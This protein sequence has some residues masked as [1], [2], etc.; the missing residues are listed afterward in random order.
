MGLP[1]LWGKVRIT[2]PLSKAYRATQLG[3]VMRGK[4]DDEREPLSAA[5]GDGSGSKWKGSLI[6]NVDVQTRQTTIYYALL[7]C[8]A[9][10]FYRY[11]VPLT[12]F[13][14]LAL[15]SFSKKN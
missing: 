13:T 12:D 10:G 1:R 11:L 4:D 15:V 8:G 9:C 6:S 14:D 7:L 5:S 2:Q 3:P